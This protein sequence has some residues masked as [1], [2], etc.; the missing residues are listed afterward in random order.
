MVE[1]LR[2][3][4]AVNE[5]RTIMV[6]VGNQFK[7][8][9]YREVN[10]VLEV[11][12]DIDVEVQ[13]GMSNRTGDAFKDNEARKYAYRLKTDLLKDAL[14]DLDGIKRDLITRTSMLVGEEY[15]T[16]DDVPIGGLI[17]MTTDKN[18]EQTDLSIKFVQPPVAE[19][20]TKTT[21]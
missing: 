12:E 11:L 13:E 16:K 15:A 8:R 7:E 6:V 1:N 4:T 3:N 19:Q 10:H 20:E 9:M 14:K 21:A 18:F 17:G 5:L 2:D